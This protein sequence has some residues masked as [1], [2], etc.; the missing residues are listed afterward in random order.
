VFTGSKK[1]KHSHSEDEYDDEPDLPLPDVDVK[2]SEQDFYKRCQHEVAI[3]H[4]IDSSY[5]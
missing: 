3:S 2:H 4:L 1:A 5:N